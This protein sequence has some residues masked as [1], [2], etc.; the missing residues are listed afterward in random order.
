[1]FVAIRWWRRR[2]HGLACVVIAAGAISPGAVAS[3]NLTLQ[4]VNPVADVGDVVEIRVYATSDSASNQLLSAVQMILGW[5]TPYLQLLGNHQAGAVPLLASGFPA[6]DPW[7]LNESNPPQNGVGMYQAF[8][9]LGNPVAATPAGALLTTLR[10]LALAPTPATPVDIL[11][12]AG[13]P[14]G[15]TIVFDG[16]TPNT[17]VT[18]VLTGTS[19][20]I[21]PA[22]AGVL[23]LVLGGMMNRRRRGL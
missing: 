16:T 4:P 13:S 3:I 21:I 5:Q 7:G 14:V 8:A 6:G 23:V 18:G 19:I 15:F 9:P 12:S 11:P 17:N 10:F 22:P 2:L 1:M 20:T